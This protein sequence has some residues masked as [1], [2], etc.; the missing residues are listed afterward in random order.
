[1]NEPRKPRVA[2][3]SPF[4][5][6][7]YGTERIVIRWITALADEFDIHIYSQRVQDVDL[8]KFTWHRVPA[9]PGPHILN[10]LFWYFANQIARAWDRAFRGLKPDI[11]FSPGVNC[12]DADVISVH[13]V[14][15][16]FVRQSAVE[17]QFSRAPL[18]AWTRLLHRRLYY[19][20]ITFLESRVYRQ[21]TNYLVLIANK[22]AADLKRFYNRT[23]RCLVL[24]LGLDHSVFNEP[25]RLAAREKARAE[26]SIGAN[27]FVVLLVGNDLRKKGMRA[28]I[29]AM[30]ALHDSRVRLLVATRDDV[31]P[32]AGAA[33]DAGVADRIRFCP[34]RKDV[35]YYY[36]AADA[37][38]G[39]SLEDTF[40]LPP[41]EAMA[42]GLP[43]LV[44]RENGTVEIIEHGVNGLILENPADSATLA[45]MMRQ[46]A[47]DPA[48]ASRIA[49]K[50]AETAR[51]F[52]WER[53]VDDVRAI[54][55][56]VLARDDR[57]PAHEAASHADPG[58]SAASK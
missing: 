47:D 41:V 43:T 9:L 50:G 13:I 55:A 45:G 21:S 25:R 26:L 12:P 22:T 40:A 42:S 54:F 3:V 11:V 39:P 57:T 10:Y 46:L 23:E 53:N 49:A 34:P 18:S 37:Y 52:T 16:E 44:S 30:K 51:Q 1:M 29:E 4:L 35:D 31:A 56:Q 28:L 20:L 27:E 5:D 24:Y 32:F 48:F 17:L 38:A 7:A 14:F 8:S 19:R 36:A 58:R 6:N 2:V 15:A 33:R